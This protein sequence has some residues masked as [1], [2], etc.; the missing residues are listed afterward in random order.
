MKLNFF[1]IQFDL[2]DYQ[3][4]VEQYSEKK[5]NEF[6]LEH[7]STHSFFRN[8]G[9]IYISDKEGS[10]E[11]NLGNPV[12]RNI[13]KDENITSALIKHIFFR[14]F[15]ERFPTRTPIDF[16]PFRFFSEKPDDDIIQPLIPEI[17]KGKIA[18][19]KMIEV[20]LRATQIGN[21]KRFGFI[22]NLQSNWVLHK[23]CA[24][25]IRE[26]FDIH[27]LDV[28]HIEQLPGLDNILAPNEDYIGILQSFEGDH[29]MVLTN[30]GLQK[31]S[32]DNLLLKKS[33]F[34]IA[35]Y[36]SH[37]TSE[38][39]S[40]RILNQVKNKRR[41]NLDAKS[42]YS[43]IVK[44]GRALF[45]DK[46]IPILFH[47]RDGFCFRVDE[48]PLDVKN[49]ID[50]RTPTFIFD[51]AATK[52]RN[53]YPDLGLINY[54]PYD[55]IS[56][57]IKSPKV[58]AICSG[59]LRGQFSKF[60]SN[61]RDGL[62]S[63]KY[64]QKGFQK[65]Y[66]LQEVNFDI[67]EIANYGN[68]DYL[69]I[70]RGYEEAKPDLAIIEIPE[71][72]R[73]LDTRSNPYYNIKAKFLS[74]E[75]PVQFITTG[76]VKNHNEYQL[77]SIAL[78]IYAKLGGTPWVLPTQRSVDKEIVIGIGHSWNRN[79]EFKGAEKNRVVGITTFLSS[80]GQYLL[81]DRI[82]DVSFD[83][84]FDELLKSL[85]NSINRLSKEQGWAQGD[86]LRLIF[87]IF[88]PI[89][90][91]EFDVV[92]RLISD[93]S[94]YNIKFAFVTISEY[95]PHLLFDP[96]Q[97]GVNQYDGGIK[98]QFVPTRGSVVFI[99]SETA[100]IQMLGAKELKTSKQGMSNPIQIKIR[101]PQGKHENKELDDLLFYDLSY[102]CQQVFSFTYLSWRSFLPGERPATMLYSNLISNLLSKM[103]GIP[104]WDPD[105]LNYG[106][107]RKKW[108]L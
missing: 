11:I 63:S 101:T 103:R 8:E 71:N 43:E 80:D 30:E 66:D 70:I 94:D 85:H 6:R 13:Y 77:N 69:S 16:Y 12:T 42:L 82:K 89:K 44:I 37:A 34:N 47:N 14:T 92:A 29:G 58:L 27:G 83:D 72:F 23:S 38:E 22:I 36:L 98:G 90:N 15:K 87:H 4:S 88:K 10:D 55:S 97:H 84:Y 53:D 61:L 79:N 7:N 25:M 81:G 62:P 49:T 59:S 105:K 40:A 31:Y 35:S 104:G 64:F 17:L 102:I 68:E 33:H 9:F 19:K 65:K 57:D 52:T 107:K 20:Q 1:P 67:R 106:M 41:E 24:E 39:S 51:P 18:Y 60:L 91:T 73:R 3:I 26:G 56:F 50:L 32:L 93:I 99:D 74:L 54:G 78:Q 2:D 76:L 100:I 96:N 75:I 21:I 86:T 108:F 5:L 46:R 48:D 95:H 45:S 28:L